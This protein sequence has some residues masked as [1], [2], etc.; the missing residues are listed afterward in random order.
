MINRAKAAF[1]R[2][3]LLNEFIPVPQALRDT[4]SGSFGDEAQQAL[5]EAQEIN[6]LNT[7]GYK[8]WYDFCVAKW[9]TK[10]D[11]GN[12]DGSQISEIIHEP[13]ND[14]DNQL[15]PSVSMNFQSAWSPPVEAYEV[16]KEL[17]FDVEATYYE[18]GMSFCGMW[19]DG[20]DS[21]YDITGDSTWVEKNIPKAIWDAENI[22]EMMAESEEFDNS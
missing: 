6:N 10:W 8:N 21:H 1:A 19:H 17:G 22:V 15:V 5:L 20:C 4:M 11:I 9:G 12:D 3:E 13:L 7:Y 14:D 2:N 18:P 16:L